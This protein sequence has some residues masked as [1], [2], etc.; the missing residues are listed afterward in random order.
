MV[1]MFIV[2]MSQLLRL[3]FP[4]ATKSMRFIL[5]GGCYFKDARA[6]DLKILSTYENGEAAIVSSRYGD[7]SVLLSGVHFEYD[8]DYLDSQ[9]LHLQKLIP[10]LKRV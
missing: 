9:D 5:M 6:Y 10:K 3:L 4:M 1:H 2:V 8:A 7:G